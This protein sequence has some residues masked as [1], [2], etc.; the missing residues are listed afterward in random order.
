MSSSRWALAVA[1]GVLLVTCGCR[2]WPVPVRPEPGRRGSSRS[3][4]PAEPDRLPRAAWTS[5]R[6]GDRV[7]QAR[8]DHAHPIPGRSLAWYGKGDA[9]VF[10]AGIGNLWFV[11]DG[12]ALGGELLA[13]DFHGDDQDRDV[14]GFEASALVRT[15]VRQS[16][17]YSVFL[18]GSGGYI[19]TDRSVPP[20][21]TPGN[22]TFSFGPG[23]EIPMDR[24][25]D[26]LGGLEFHHMSNALGRENPR[27]PSQNEVMFWFGMGIHW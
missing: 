4:H 6:A 16:E 17:D 19:R 2:A 18:G 24:R 1:G 21:G 14:A 10:G 27:N 12:W 15:Y 5:H 20:E 3:E 26:F 22:W 7:V 25:T 9:D 11:A 23:I 8:V 13:K